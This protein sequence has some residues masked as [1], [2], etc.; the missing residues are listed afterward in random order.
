MPRFFLLR[1]LVTQSSRPARLGKFSVSRPERLKLIP[2]KRSS[3]ALPPQQA[4]TLRPKK[5][6]RRIAVN[7]ER[8]G[9]RISE[10]LER[11]K[12]G[13]QTAGRP[14]GHDLRFYASPSFRPPLHGISTAAP[15]TPS[16]FSASSA[17][18]ASLIG[19]FCTSVCTGI[20]AAVFRNSRPS[21]RVLLATL[22]ITRSWY[23]RS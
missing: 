10:Q 19:N 11:R 17:R 8:I 1:N 5:Q 13:N 23:S 4:Q 9:P 2:S 15:R 21:S 6:S 16:L 22:R 18:F 12:S 3:F 20:A 7:P 14:A